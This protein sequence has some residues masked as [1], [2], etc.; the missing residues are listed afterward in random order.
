MGSKILHKAAKENYAPLCYS[1]K[2]SLQNRNSGI[3]QGYHGMHLMCLNQRKRGHPCTLWEVLNPLMGME[4]QCGWLSLGT[5]VLL[6]EIERTL[7]APWQPGTLFFLSFPL[8]SWRCQNKS[9][10]PV[11]FSLFLG[12]CWLLFLALLNFQ[13]GLELL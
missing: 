7:G 6:T 5:Q 12:W 10:F 3:G 1:R 8:I 2:G 11:Y 9:F 4:K 13:R